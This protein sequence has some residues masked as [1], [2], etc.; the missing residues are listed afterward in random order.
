MFASRNWTRLYARSGTTASQC[1]TQ[2]FLSAQG[3]CYDNAAMESFF[4][5]I[6][7]EL[8]HQQRWHSLEQV[9]LALFDYIE[10]FYNRRRLHSALNYESPLERCQS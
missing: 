2:G 1:S 4:S 9:K 10:T 6:K 7:T 5:T 3:Y 8:L